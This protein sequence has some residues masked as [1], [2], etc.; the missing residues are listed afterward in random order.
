[1]QYH[2]WDA[3][4]N[5]PTLPRWHKRINNRDHFYKKGF[6][7]KSVRNRCRHNPEGPVRSIYFQFFP[8]MTTPL[9][10]TIRWNGRIWIWYEKRFCERK[11][12]KQD[13]SILP[14]YQ[15][16]EE[17]AHDLYITASITTNPTTILYG[18]LERVVRKHLRTRNQSSSICCSPSIL[19]IGPTW[20]LPSNAWKA[21][22]MWYRP[23]IGTP[24]K[25]QTTGLTDGLAKTKPDRLI[26][27][28]KQ[29]NK[30]C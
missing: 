13:A 25:A 16:G 3:L 23:D 17:V 2:A 21:C 30:A 24:R 9:T 8:S 28:Q 6:P 29:R 10:S 12:P 14:H 15:Y 5:N 7:S 4:I 20:I 11:S 22:S 19:S 27:K 18:L 1:M 26:R